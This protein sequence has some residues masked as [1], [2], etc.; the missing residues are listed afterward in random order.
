MI[1]LLAQANAARLQGDFA[2]AAERKLEE[3][4]AIRETL[5]VYGTLAPGRAN[6]HI[7]APLGG[8][9]T[10]G[11]VEG[12]LHP[13]GWGATMGY[14]ACR[15]RIGGP[16]IPVH[17]LTSPLLPDAWPELDAFEGPAYVRL[18][19]PVLRGGAL[20]TIANLYAAA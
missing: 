4:F 6:H 14:P 11:I 15:P 17:V 12:E 16:A 5:A 19:V 3:R 7:V 10:E 2:S 18:L 9:W 20:Y 13:E 8:T 1:E